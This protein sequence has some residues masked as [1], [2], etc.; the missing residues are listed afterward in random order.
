[1]S[2]CDP[3]PP[4]P[5]TPPT[6]TTSSTPQRCSTSTH[7]HWLDLLDSKGPLEDTARP[8]GAAAAALNG[9][10]ERLISL[11]QIYLFIY[12]FLHWGFTP[13]FQETSSLFQQPVIKEETF[14]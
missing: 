13:P 14:Q 2:P 1:M 12:L 10:A 11:K 4:L 7:P 3:A 8:R 6:T 9:G 5:A